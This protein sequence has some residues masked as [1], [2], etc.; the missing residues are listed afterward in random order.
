MLSKYVLQPV[1]TLAC[2]SAASPLSDGDDML[3]IYRYMN[4]RICCMNK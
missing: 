2:E 3:Y 1:S 4:I